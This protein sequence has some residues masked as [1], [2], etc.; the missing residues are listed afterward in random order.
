MAQAAT[1]LGQQ[2][3]MCVLHTDHDDGSLI[4]WL[5]LSTTV[6]LLHI[7]IWVMNRQLDEA[8]RV[9]DVQGAS[10]RAEAQGVPVELPLRG[11]SD[12][13]HLAD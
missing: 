7:V 3:I 13:E 11:P 8:K 12:S 4:M 1:G 9:C 2:D 6:L 10:G 5:L